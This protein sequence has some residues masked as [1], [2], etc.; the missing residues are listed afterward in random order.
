MTASREFDLAVVGAGIVGLSCA[1]AAA[2][3]RL[4]V[5]VIERDARARGAS[6][7]N[8]GLIT[9][10]GQDRDRVWPRARR[11]REIWEEVA[12]EAGIRI[13]SRGLWVAARR[14]ESAAV[15][16][17]F[18]RSDMA[19]GCRLLTPAEAQRRCPNLRTSGLKAVLWSPHELRVESRDAIPAIADW[20]ARDHGVTFRWETAVHGVAPPII[21]TSRGRIFAEA[22]VVCP[23]DDL[24]T[25]FPE[26]L[27]AA[28]VGR[29]TLQML[30]LD[31]PGFA[32]P[33]TVMSDLS[34]AR[35]GGF[36]SLAE[37]NALR[38][39]LQAEQSEHLRHGIHLIIAQASDGSL[40]VGDSH[41]DGAAPFAN[42]SVYELLLDEYRAVMGQLPPAV[43]ERWMGTYAVASD[44][45]VFIDAP[46]PSIR[47]VVVTGGVGASTG[48][49]L[50]EE[51]I[52]ELFG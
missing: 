32:L 15:L 30:R 43:R 34:L 36:A 44:R 45:A 19:E 21:E 39:R 1:L 50:G 24:V 33:G 16:D 25:L 7:R 31:S 10:T 28:G 13:V 14:F 52:G 20:L 11:S 41:H 35:Y 27:N 2:K 51:V 5:I 38:Q 26:R 42:E 3:R 29:C 22:T 49:A 18:L 6:V 23:G 8:F 46:S 37:A 12:A 48:F 9:I 17:A 40:V 4:K 47:L